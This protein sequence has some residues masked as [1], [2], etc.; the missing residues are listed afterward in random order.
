MDPASA[1]HRARRRAVLTQRELAARTGVA[2]STIA[3]I[4]RGHDDPRVMTLSRLLDACDHRLRASRAAGLGIDR[5]LIARLLDQEPIARLELAA[6]E[7]NA[8]RAL[9]IGGLQP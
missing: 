1:L 4:E 7:W 6:D 9:P 5:T 8:L 3:R 2:Q